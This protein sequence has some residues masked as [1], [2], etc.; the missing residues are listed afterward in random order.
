MKEFIK[1]HP[2]LISMVAVTFVGLL[3]SSIWT[4]QHFLIVLPLFNSLVI[5]ILTSSINRYGQLLGAINSLIYGGVYF[6]FGLYGI[7]TSTI[8]VNAPIMFITFILWNKKAYKHSTVLKKLS[9]KQRV[10][11]FMLLL[12]LMLGSFVVLKLIN[13]E[14]HILLDT[15][16]SVLG[17]VIAFLMMFAFVEAYPLSVIS[18]LLNLI[19]FMIMTVE[20]IKQIPYLIFSLY[21]TIMNMMAYFCS[22]RLYAEQQE[23]KN[24]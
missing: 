5:M 20:D 16:I 4:G 19:L 17:Y 11:G 21:S 2:W 3:I 14:G 6:Y 9:V 7:A 12:A 15:V 23:E 18:G 10:I 1:K 22:K 24:S 8:L 13:P